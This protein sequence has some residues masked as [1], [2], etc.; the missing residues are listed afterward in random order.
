MSQHCGGGG[1][2]MHLVSVFSPFF[3]HCGTKTDTSGKTVE[4][5]TLFLILTTLVVRYLPT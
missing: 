2:E 1:G 3:Y 4:E 5:V